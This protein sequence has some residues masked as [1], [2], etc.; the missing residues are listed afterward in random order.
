MHLLAIAHSTWVTGRGGAT[1]AAAEGLPAAMAAPEANG[2]LP[3]GSAAHSAGP[4]SSTGD[5]EN[6]ISQAEQLKDEANQT[7]KGESFGCRAHAHMGC[8]MLSAL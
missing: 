2:A 8:A 4:S 5:T 3:C 7:F 6:G 1:A